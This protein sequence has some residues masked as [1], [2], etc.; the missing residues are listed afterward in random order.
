MRTRARTANLSLAAGSEVRTYVLNGTQ[1]VYQDTRLPVT[2]QAMDE[3]IID[4]EL[5][6]RMSGYCKHS[7]F[8]T[9]YADARNQ[10]FKW[11]Q[12]PTNYTSVCSGSILYYYV[13]QERCSATQRNLSP[14]VTVNSFDWGNASYTALE[15]MRPTIEDGLLTPNF[16]A[17][18]IETGH[19][20]HREVIRRMERAEREREYLLRHNTK[21]AKAAGD[22]SYRRSW[23]KSLLQSLAPGSSVWNRTIGAFARATRYAA[24]ANLAYQFAIRPTVSDAKK[25]LVVIDK[26]R[27]I[28]T[29]L[30]RKAGTRQVRHYK[31]PVDNLL[32]L[33]SDR[34]EVLTLLFNTA[35]TSVR[36]TAFL[37]RPTYHASMLFTY[38][39]TALKGL[40][41]DLT[42]LVTAFGANKVA[43]I[44]WEAIP[45][46]FVVDWFVNVGDLIRRWEGQYV[47]PLP[48]V[49]HDFSHSLKYGYRTKLEWNWGN[50]AVY[51]DLAYR[52]TVVYERRRDIPSLWDS[53]SV[54][55]P[56]LNQAGLGLSL[57]IMRMDG[58][59][60][61]KRR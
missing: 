50:G 36:K 45:Y 8:A 53:L 2:Y 59:T 12:S 37:F 26:Y 3:T 19:L 6:K 5:L 46:S 47:D 55:S 48:I 52:D 41:G 56:N 60:K 57:I 33:P 14:T 31:R 13:L 34:T 58:I 21:A 22:A 61:W 17:E 10:T 39:A 43:S 54:H 15:Q 18:L 29:E 23:E 28:V 25:M 9:W 49:I 24:W 27:S 1:M 4:Q 38:D 32:V 35:N 42:G 51:T 20:T 40:L 16:T 30:I 7:K 11:F 44:I